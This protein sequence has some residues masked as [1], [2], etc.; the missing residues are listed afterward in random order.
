MAINTVATHVHEGIMYKIQQESSTGM[1]YAVASHAVE[2][3]LEIITVWDSINGIPVTA[4]GAGAFAQMPKLKE[5][6]ILE[7]TAIQIAG[8]AF[9]NCPQLMQVSSFA[10]NTSFAT[11]AFKDCP[12]LEEVGASGEAF[13]IGQHVFHNCPKLTRLTTDIA[14]V[15]DF[16]FGHS[17]AF[18][19]L[20]FAQNAKFTP[21][22]MIGATA[23]EL[24]FFGDVVL[25]ETTTIDIFKDFRIFCKQRS[26]FADLVFEGFHVEFW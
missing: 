15:T 12:N 26:M 10:K 24:L 16:A 3:D 7:N 25:L 14:K 21:N 1:Q 22:S 9:S 20:V 4:I 5:V 17:P 13:L 19:G 11:Q 6:T 2:K 18:E 23:K 8:A